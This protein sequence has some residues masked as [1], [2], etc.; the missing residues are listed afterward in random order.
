MEKIP[1]D[2]APPGCNFIQ[3]HS[4]DPAIQP[5]LN[6]VKRVPVQVVGLQLSQENDVDGSIEGLA[7]VQIAYCLVDFLIHQV[8]RQVTTG[9]QA[10]QEGYLQI[11]EDGPAP[12]APLFT[13][14]KHF[15]TQK[16]KLLLNMF[17]YKMM[18]LHN[19]K[20][21]PVK[22]FT[23]VNLVNNERMSTKLPFFLG[24]ES[25]VYH[26]GNDYT[27]KINLKD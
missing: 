20:S 1:R 3:H 16:P 24:P 23:Y 25:R 9:L 7:E 15:N 8:F 19:R 22:M 13:N 18:F 17:L 26:P 5:I 6:P 27:M 2:W 21:C 14:A 10:G 11:S 12:P 4:L